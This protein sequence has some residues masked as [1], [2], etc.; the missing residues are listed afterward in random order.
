MVPKMV[1]KPGPGGDPHG[2]DHFRDRER[3]ALTE[4]TAEKRG[5]RVLA[6]MGPANTS[7]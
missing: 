5:R 6:K 3:L 2:V 7:R 4:S 1:Q